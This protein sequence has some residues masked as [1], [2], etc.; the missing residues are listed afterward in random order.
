MQLIT[1]AGTEGLC[2]SI[3]ADCAKQ[4]TEPGQHRAGGDAE[5]GILVKWGFSEASEG[6]GA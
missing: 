5:T 4:S 3:N 6:K 2:N 1:A